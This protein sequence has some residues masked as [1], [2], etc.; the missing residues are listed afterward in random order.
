MQTGP[1][2]EECQERFP[3]LWKVVFAVLMLV[4]G[5]LA[6]IEVTL[7]DE[8]QSK[9]DDAGGCLVITLQNLDKAVTEAFRRGAVS[10]YL[11]T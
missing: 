10:C 5:P 8:E 2:S 6:A 7:T 3:L 11:R 9:C 4:T 1:A